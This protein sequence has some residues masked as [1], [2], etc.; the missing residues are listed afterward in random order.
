MYTFVFGYKPL[1][2]IFTCLFVNI[3]ANTYD[4][5]KIKFYSQYG[6]DCIELLSIERF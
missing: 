3:V 6:E 4:H 1:N 2:H 5:A